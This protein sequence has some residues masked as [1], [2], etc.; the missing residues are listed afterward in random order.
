MILAI[1]TPNT[2]HHAVI[3]TTKTQYDFWG[4]ITDI[5]LTVICG[6]EKNIDDGLWEVEMVCLCLIL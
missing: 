1:G 6:K 4:G 2:A 3:I 5:F